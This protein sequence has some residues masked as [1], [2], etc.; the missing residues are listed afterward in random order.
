MIDPIEMIANHTINW[1]AHLLVDHH[2]DHAPMLAARCAAA[3]KAR[4]QRRPGL[5]L[6]HGPRSDQPTDRRHPD[7]G[8]RHDPLSGPQQ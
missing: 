6:G 2:G 3:G 5:D 7:T 1:A 4:R 8:R